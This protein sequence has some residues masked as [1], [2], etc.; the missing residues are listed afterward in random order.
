MIGD[1]KVGRPTQSAASK[2]QML[3]HCESVMGEENY[4]MH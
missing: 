3:I 1:K 2:Q 4:D